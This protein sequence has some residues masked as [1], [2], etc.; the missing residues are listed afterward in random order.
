MDG[1][2]VLLQGR[3]GL[4]KKDKELD[5]YLKD[6]RIALVGPSSHLI[7]KKAGWFIDAFDVIVRVGELYP[8]GMEKDYGSRTNI[9][10]NSLNSDTPPQINREFENLKKKS[11]NP[12][13]LE[14][15]ICPQKPKDDRGILISDNFKKINYFVENKIKFH[16]IT[17]EYYSFLISQIKTKSNTGINIIPLLLNYDIKNLFITGYSFYAQGPH[18]NQCYRPG[19]EGIT[20]PLNPTGHQQGPQI[21]YFKKNILNKKCGRKII[22][23][24]YL[25][26]ILGFAHDRIINL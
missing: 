15:V 19:Y 17:Q 11:I 4:Y 6:K 13:W 12:D 3:D 8:L 9:Y 24:S 10:V 1:I 16:Q 21:E 5:L 18:S 7:N 26:T 22:I 14:F 20:H 23:D 25:D 2:Y